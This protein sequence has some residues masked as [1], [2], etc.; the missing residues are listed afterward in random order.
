MGESDELAEDAGKAR[1]RGEAV[2][3]HLLRNGRDGGS[4]KK[5]SR[6]GRGPTNPSGVCFAAVDENFECAEPAVRVGVRLE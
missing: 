6:R 1:G 3:R 5:R 2:E 4:A